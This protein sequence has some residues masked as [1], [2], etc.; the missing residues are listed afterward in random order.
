[1]IVDDE[2]GIRWMVRRFLE[3][4]G[5]QVIEAENGD[6]CLEALTT[7]QNA[8]IDLVVLDCNMP[9]MSGKETLLAL[10]ARQPK[11]KI[12]L[13]C[14]SLALT[15]DMKEADWRKEG[16]TAFLHKP[17]LPTELVKAVQNHL[18]DQPG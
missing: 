11:L 12:M 4:A 6:A 10:K 13:S 17:Y 14:G 16:V 15:S 18:A 9:G 5:Y 7:E 2:A 3:S 1:M 8:P